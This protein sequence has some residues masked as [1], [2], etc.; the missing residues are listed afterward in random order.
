[1]IDRIIRGFVVDFINVNELFQFAI[2][3]VA[4]IF[5]VLGIF[6]IAITVIMKERQS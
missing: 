6:G 4:D 3:N 5:I 1:M 2:F